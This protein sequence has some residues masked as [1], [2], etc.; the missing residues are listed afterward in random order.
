MIEPA[1]WHD[2]ESPDPIDYTEED[3]VEV[4]E[5]ITAT[6]ALDQAVDDTPVQIPVSTQDQSAETD[7]LTPVISRKNLKRKRRQKE[8]SRKKI[9]K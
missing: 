1:M 8:A 2:T 4:P 5:K 9:A 3:F 7:G 6:K